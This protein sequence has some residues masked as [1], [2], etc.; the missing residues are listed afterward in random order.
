[1][2]HTLFRTAASLKSVHGSIESK[3]SQS[4]IEK[5]GF[6]G[7]ET[8]FIPEKQAPFRDVGHNLMMMN[9]RLEHF[10][11]KACPGLDPGWGPVRFKKTR[12]IKSSRKP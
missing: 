4:V 10:P 2:T 8:A 1:M 6:F 9:E 5:N 3:R 7:P 12:Q 11:A